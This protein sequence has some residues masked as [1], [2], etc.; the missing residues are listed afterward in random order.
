M[1]NVT[2]FPGLKVQR[3]LPKTAPVYTTSTESEKSKVYQCGGVWGAQSVK[4]PTLDF[5]SGH[6]LVVLGIEL[7]VGLCTNSMEPAWDSLFLP[8]PLSPNIKKIFFNK[9]YCVP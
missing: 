3:H 4:C 2:Q 8:S 1:F 5:S 9:I 6:D 7:R